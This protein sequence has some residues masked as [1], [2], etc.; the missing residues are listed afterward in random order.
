[1]EERDTPVND[2]QGVQL[3]LEGEA[4]GKLVEEVFQVKPE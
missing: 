4:L 3:P 2:S 1:L